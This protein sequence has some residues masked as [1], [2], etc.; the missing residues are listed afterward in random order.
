MLYEKNIYVHI[1][2]KLSALRDQQN[3]EV[4][5]WVD[6]DMGQLE[7]ET[8]PV[9]FPCVL[10]SFPNADDFTTNRDQ[11]QQG[12]QTVTLR[13]AFKLFERTHS[14]ATPQ[15]RGEALQIF[16]VKE[17]IH[18]ALQATSGNCFGKLNRVGSRLEPRIDLRVF[19]LTYDCAVQQAA[20]RPDYRPV[21]DYT[22]VPITLDLDVDLLRPDGQP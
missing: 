12:N 15:Y 21:G 5:R 11:S 13:V 19:E 17:A 6:F 1:L 18:N 7:M 9:S 2:T 4:V 8:P 10:V 22:N 16:E 20:P 14:K 3:R